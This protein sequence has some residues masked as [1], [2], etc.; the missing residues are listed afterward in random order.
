MK[1][2]EDYNEYIKFQ[3]IGFVLSEENKRN[4][5]IQEPFLK[6]LLLNREQC[7]KPEQELYNFILTN[8]LWCL[9][10]YKHKPGQGAPDRHVL[11][12]HRMLDKELVMKQ[13][14]DFG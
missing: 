3:Q 5:Q 1:K 11:V 14:F 2:I 8:W 12:G 6:R 13:A 7:T 10:V 4:K 9:P